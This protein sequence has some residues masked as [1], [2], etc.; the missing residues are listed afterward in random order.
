MRIQLTQ[1]LMAMATSTACC[2]NTVSLRSGLVKV[3]R[4]CTERQVLTIQYSLCALVT[5]KRFVVFLQDTNSLAFMTAIAALGVSADNDLEVSFM[6]SRI[7]R[8]FGRSILFC[9]DF[10]SA[11]QINSVCLP[12]KAGEAVGVIAVL[13]KP[14]GW[15]ITGNVEYNQLDALLR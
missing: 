9:V 11:S 10:L 5:G 8:Y 15:K 7:A 13:S 4:L 14:D 12:R 3:R 6:P 2:I 1:S